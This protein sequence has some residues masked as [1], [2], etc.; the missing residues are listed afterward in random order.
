ML[1][2]NILH[3]YSYFLLIFILIYRECVYYNRNESNSKEKIEPKEPSGGSNQFTG[4][5]RR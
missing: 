1:N 2:R 3:K 4:E 5:K